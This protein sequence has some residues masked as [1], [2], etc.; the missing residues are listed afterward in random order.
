[1]ISKKIT[2]RGGLVRM[3]IVI[4]VI[5]LVISYFGLNLRNL[6]NAPTTQDNLGYTTGLISTVWN[7]YLRRPAT[8]LWN[9]IFIN[10]IWEPAIN[11]LT[12]MKNGEPTNVQNYSS[13]TMPTNQPIVR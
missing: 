7:N 6:V 4:V 10:L 2:N 13:S 11:N 8:Y 3:V 5:L 1:M 12:R 9:N